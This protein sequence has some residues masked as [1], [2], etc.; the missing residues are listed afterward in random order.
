M[1]DSKTRHPIVSATGEC[2]LADGRPDASFDTSAD[3]IFAGETVY[4]TDTSSKAGIQAK[5]L[6]LSWNPSD[7]EIGETITFTLA[8][9]SGDIDQA[10]WNFGE[11]GLREAFHRRLQAATCITTARQLPLPMLRAGPKAVSVTWNSPAAVLT[12]SVR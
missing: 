1:V 9:V 3:E 7:P 10:T 2:C 6:S 8:E 11:D 4:F 12:V 5:A